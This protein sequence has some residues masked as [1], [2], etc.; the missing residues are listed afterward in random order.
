M[1]GFFRREVAVKFH[2]VLGRGIARRAVG[3]LAVASPMVIGFL[4]VPL[5]FLRKTGALR[6]VRWVFRMCWRVVVGLIRLMTARR[7]RRVRRPLAG[8]F[9]RLFK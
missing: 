4:A 9:I 3:L 8:A 7:R 6:V 1:K 2:S 5:T